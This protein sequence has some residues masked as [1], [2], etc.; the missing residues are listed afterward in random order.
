MARVEHPGGHLLIMVI[1]TW[2]ERSTTL[3]LLIIEL[4]LAVVFP[5]YAILSVR[6]WNQVGI[7]KINDFNLA[8]L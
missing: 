4:T 5:L 7:F 1:M 3:S 8:V 2:C 6:Q